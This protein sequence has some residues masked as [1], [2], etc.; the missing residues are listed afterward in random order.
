MTA[1]IT[2]EP[3]GRVIDAAPGETVLDAADRAGIRLSRQCRNGT[4]GTC[5]AGI[6]SGEIAQGRAADGSA[7]LCRAVPTGDLVVAL[8]ASSL[9]GM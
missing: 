8:D 4:C 3:F 7:L 2:F 5:R 9:T 6:V 1:T